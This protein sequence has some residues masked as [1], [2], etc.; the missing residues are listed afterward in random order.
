MVAKADT[1][2]D[3]ECP[4]P[5]T[6]VGNRRGKKIRNANQKSKESS[7]SKEGRSARPGKG[8]SANSSNAV[9]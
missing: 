7:G 5:S 4:E 3:G 6:S 1:D 2:T 9:S 8:K